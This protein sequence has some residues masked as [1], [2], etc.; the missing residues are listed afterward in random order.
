MGEAWV[1]VDS[2]AYFR[3][4][5]GIHPLL[6]R[7]FGKPQ[8]YLG[9]IEELDN[10]YKKN[11]RLQSKFYWVSQ[12]KYAENRADCFALT[13]D[14]KTAIGNTFFFLRDFKREK[15]LGTSTVDLTCL[16]YGYELKIPVVTD[17]PDMLVVAKEFEIEIWGALQLL[18]TM[19]ENEFIAIEKVDELVELWKYMRD[20]PKNFNRDLQKY[21][22]GRGL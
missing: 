18:K 6:K 19:V 13:R 4:A 15:N 22:A 14:Q 16:A 3:L 8:Y 17:D 1:L 12:P 7:K 20:C 2:N 9:V 11:P 21:F 5:Q 10:E